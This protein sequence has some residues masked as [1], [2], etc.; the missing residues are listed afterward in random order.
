MFYKPQ[1]REAS[2]S[3]HKHEALYEYN[4]LSFQYTIVPIAA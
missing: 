1:G 3:V 4:S 2:Q